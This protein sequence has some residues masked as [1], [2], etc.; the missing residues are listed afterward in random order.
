MTFSVSHWSGRLG[1]NIQQ[2]ANCI[3]AAQKYKCTF[4]QKLD[5]DIIPKY[6]VNFEGLYASDYTGEGR[7]YAWEALVHCEKGIYEGGNETGLG[8]EHIYRNMRKIC[9]NYIA[10]NLMV[11]KKE[12]IG[13]DTI[14][15]HL[16]SG[17][18]YH[19]IF[20]P[21]TN[22]VPNPLIFYL[23]LIESFDKCILITEQDRQNPIVHE[24]QKI[25]KVELQSSTVAEDFATL[26]SAKNVALSG[27]GTFA[28][29]AA[30]CSSEIE[31]L[32]T[33]DLLLTE[34]LNYTMMYN[35][36]VE[37]QIMELD[38]YIPVFP[39]GWKNT[40]EQRKFIMDYR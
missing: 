23:N 34:H 27:V 25:D 32:F 3:M 21:P 8:V 22:Y 10:P 36:D 26:M 24:L 19:R 4:R 5:H 6:D 17:D 40:E 12:P 28:M 7:Y 30:L 1:N 33:T 14:V 16:R 9:K 31:N 38:N 15:M 39:C 18:N 20:D 13:D 29:A 2:V 11:P 35:T 37:V